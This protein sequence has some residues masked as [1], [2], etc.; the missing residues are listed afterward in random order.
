MLSNAA[1]LLGRLTNMTE[2]LHLKNFAARDG[3]RPITAGHFQQL[4]ENALDQISPLGAGAENNAAAPD[5]SAHLLQ[6]H[7]LINSLA[8][9]IFNALDRDGNGVL[10]GDETQKLNDALAYLRRELLSASRKADTE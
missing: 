2:W 6:K 1:A 5:A 10:E 8:P 3:A 7:Q 4:V 9:Q